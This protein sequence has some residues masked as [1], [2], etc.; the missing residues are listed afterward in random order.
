VNA[1]SF[2]D[3]ISKNEIGNITS[4]RNFVLLGNPALKMVYPEYNVRKFTKNKKKLL[5]LYYN[6]IEKGEQFLKK[7]KVELNFK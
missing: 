7:I 3:D 4:I 6:G 1:D 5:K 2:L